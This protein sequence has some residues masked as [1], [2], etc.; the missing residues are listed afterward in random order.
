MTKD[1]EKI[2]LIRLLQKKS[3]TPLSDSDAELVVERLLLLYRKLIHKPP[4]E[5]DQAPH[6]SSSET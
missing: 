1:K 4:H 6:T 3:K 2:A 5:S